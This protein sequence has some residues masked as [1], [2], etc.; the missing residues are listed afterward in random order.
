MERDPGPE[1]EPPP[2]GHPFDYAEVDV[3]RGN[4]RA[5]GFWL[6]QDF[7]PWSMGLDETERLRLTRDHWLAAHPAPI[8]PRAT[9]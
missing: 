1:P 5:R 4:T 7:S 9:H 2:P 6:K 3:A 8:E